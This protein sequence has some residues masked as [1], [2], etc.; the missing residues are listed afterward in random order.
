MYFY[1]SYS[2]FPVEEGIWLFPVLAI[3]TLLVEKTFS[4]HGIVFV[5]IKKSVECMCESVSRF[6]LFCSIDLCVSVPPPI[7]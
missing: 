1:G 2:H 5:C 6:S 4:L 7:L 3:V